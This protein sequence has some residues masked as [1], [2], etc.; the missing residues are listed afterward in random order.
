MERLMG[1]E[2]EYAFRVAGPRGGVVDRV[3]ALHDL[4]EI[5]RVELPGLPS[6]SSNGIFLGNGGRLYVDTGA[7][8]EWCTPESANPWDVVRYLAAGEQILIG[9]AEKLVK[10]QNLGNATFYKSNV[11][12]S[13]TGATWGAHENYMHRAD[14]VRLP[15]ALIPFLV[16]RVVITGAGGFDPTTS[17]GCRFTLSPRAFHITA[18]VTSNS[19][20]GRGI[21]HTKDEPLC[22]G[23]HHRLHV[24]VGESLCSNTAN[25][26]K[27]A[28]TT[29]VVAL[30]E[31]N[32]NPGRNV[33]LR[34]P[35]EALRQYA[36]DP[37]CKA[38]AEA[39]DGTRLTALQIQE[40]YL[41]LARHHQ[42]AAFMPPWADRA[43]A[44]WAS[45]LE[46]LRHAPDSVATCLDWAIKHR[47]YDHRIT[48]RGFTW[49][50]LHQ[51]SS[52]LGLLRTCADLSPVPPAD[53]GLT[54]EYVLNP[55]SPLKDIV[56]QL[57]PHLARRGLTWDQFDHYLKL[58]LELFEIDTRFGELSA[59]GIFNSLD[60]S[61][62]LQH[63][64]PGVD[65]IPHAVAHPP[66]IGRARLRGEVIQRLHGKG[67]HFAC[68]WG[69]IVDG[70]R[71]VA[72]DLQ[73]PWASTENWS[74]EAA[75]AGDTARLRALLRQLGAQN[76]ATDVPF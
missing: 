68:D 5:A 32:L 17:T 57:D 8:Q 76:S 7:H 18:S 64:F 27:V 38:D 74:A 22:N 46:R 47:I 4:N 13:G 19:T 31:A 28:T 48:R 69:F 53:S 33:K 24:L 58:R 6:L 10:R 23:G 9:L 21:Y 12:Y 49:Q 51:W 15:E 3:A 54:A 26:L 59:G 55:E 70:E 52:L 60:R 36:S 2:N 34:S 29:L 30:A 72:L 14:P 35:V 45:M 67:P 11:D 61:G 71:K 56:R 62:V 16:S 42:A 50:I 66:A 63:Q 39:A 25:W 43:I 44:E 41:N 75:T 1:L 37:T 73:D 20:A 65:N 40:H